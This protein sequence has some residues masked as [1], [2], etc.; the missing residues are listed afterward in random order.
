MKLHQND[1]VVHSQLG[2]GT[3]ISVLQDSVIVRF[4]DNKIEQCP[5]EE[6]SFL[7]DVSSELQNV[8]RANF[9]E[10]VARVQSS[11]IQTINNKWGVFSRST[12]DLLPHQLWVCNQVLK[13]WPVRYLV[14][15]DVG[16]GK[17]IEAGLIIWSLKASHKA[18][19]ILI[20]TPA[21]LTYQW[22]ERLHSMFD[23][24]FDVYTTENEKGKINY[25]DGHNHVIASAST[26]Q[27]DN[28]D[29]Q[30]RILESSPWDLVIVDEAHHM[31]A[32]ERQGE[33]LQYKFLEQ[34]EEC[35]RVLSVI[36]FTGTPHRGFDYGFLS[37]MHLVQP[38]VFDPK[39][40]I[41]KQY[42]QLSK[43][44]IRNNKQ[45]TV[46]M[47]GKKLFHEIHQHPKEFSY[48]PEEA[49]FY[50]KLSDFIEEGNAYALSKSGSVT[51]SIQLVLIA[52]Q[53]LASSS[54]AAV[55]SAL[56][57]RKKNLQA[58]KE[59]K[60]KE[61][62]SSYEELFVALN[63][64]NDGEEN[65]LYVKSN[66]IK[67]TG[68]FQL[69]KDEINN[70]DY[71][72]GLGNNIRHESRIDEII[73][74]VET[75]YANENVLFFTEYKKTQAL[76]MGELMKK[77]GEDSVTFVNGDESL[78]D[79]IMSNGSRKNFAI[80]RTEA[81][82]K[83]NDGKVRFLISTEAA[84]EGIDLQKNCHVL[85]HAD[86]P[87]N[88]MRLH[89][90]VGRINRYGQTKDV[91]VVTLRNPDTVETMI[92]QTLE[93]K[94]QSITKA[95]TAGMD[96][97]D[98][99]ESLVLGSQSSKFYD[100]L[101]YNGIVKAKKS[102]NVNDWFDL[103]SKTFGGKDT[104]SLLTNMVGNAAKFNLTNLAEVPKV[105]LPD[106]QNFFLRTIKLQ[107]R[108]P[109]ITGDKISFLTPQEWQNIFGVLPRYENL[110]FRRKMEGGEN[111]KNICGVGHIAFNKC[112]E[113]ADRIT[114]SV[115]SIKGEKSYFIYKIYDKKTYSAGRITK[116][117]IVIVYDSESDFAKQIPLDSALKIVNEIEK[118]APYH[119]LNYEPECVKK[120]ALSK[121]HD[122][123]YALPDLT[124]EF[125][126][127]GQSG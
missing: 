91:E 113:F 60:K 69:M 57:T 75:E 74:I 48:T 111:P 40:D 85:I 41:S 45:N 54:I 112:L 65:E 51:T 58:I 94:I 103:D 127:C 71:L 88:P 83:F 101:Y 8:N 21:P 102:G 39:K 1:K 55:T 104:I 19:R 61:I 46:D 9:D 13:E 105:D 117:L 6:L 59:N 62:N 23:L 52:L 22:Q 49:K 15:D 37:L 114:S 34:L 122:Y 97:P 126:L 96:D 73:R 81:A 68:I 100:D 29:R 17:T 27:F 106:L 28:N 63:N 99:L 72:I 56:E 33:T 108:R 118:D 86:I 67:K 93:L 125:V 14:A 31:N 64:G 35:N 47:N 109:V 76:L 79:V 2:T 77:W 70:L 36:L 121:I 5:I 123:H 4:A 78:S 18:H 30:K 26:M 66:E 87:W 53:K 12:I 42:S 84:G 44:F 90:R 16:L 119:F 89:Q 43:Y 11:I 7:Q 24:S 107:N 116:D 95:F 50:E 80:K 10:T 82:D 98:D 3:V 92:W 38:S 124:L 110:V 20:L 25:W 115:C 32:T 120:L